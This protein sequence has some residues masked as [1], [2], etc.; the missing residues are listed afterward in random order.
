MCILFINV[1][2]GSTYLKAIPFLEEA[3]SVSSDDEEKGRIL[4][5]LK[6]IF[7]SMRDFA[8]CIDIAELCFYLKLLF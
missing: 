8:K 2:H 3:Y 6:R 7:Y 1:I 4:K 5:R